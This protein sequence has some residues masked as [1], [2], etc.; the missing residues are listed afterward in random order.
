MY[1]KVKLCKFFKYTTKH[2]KAALEAK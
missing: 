1:Q 2:T